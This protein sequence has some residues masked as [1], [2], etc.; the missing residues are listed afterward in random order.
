MARVVCINVALIICGPP[1]IPWI[2]YLVGCGHGALEWWPQLEIL[3]LA[4][5]V[6]INVALIICGPPNIPWISYLVG[7][8]H[9]ALEW[10]PQLRAVYHI[11]GNFGRCKFSYKRPLDLQKKC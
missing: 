3:Y 9:G 7:C 5:V 11:A 1:N 4:R 8:G 10:W 6:C 2:S